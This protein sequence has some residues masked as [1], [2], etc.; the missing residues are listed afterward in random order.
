[1]SIF[2]KKGCRY[3]LVNEGFLVVNYK[4]AEYKEISLG[5]MWTR[6]FYWKIHHA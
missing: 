3:K 6:V 1:M 2:S 5:F 4:Y